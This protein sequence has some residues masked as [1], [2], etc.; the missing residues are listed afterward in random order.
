MNNAI[1]TGVIV[2]ILVL[3]ILP[4]YVWAQGI[5]FLLYED[6]EGRFTIE[7][8]SEWLVQPAQT[9]FGEI[10]VAFTSQP[11]D[12]QNLTSVD[13]RIQDDVGEGDPES[14]ANYLIDT[15]PSGVPDFNLEEGADCSKYTI[16]GERACSIIFSR[17]GQFLPSEYTVMQVVSLI[18]GNSYIITYA[19]F[20]RE[21]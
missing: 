11:S 9:R 20:L 5:E 8:P 21:F 12:Q 7:Y 3:N 15:Y 6:P 14:V 19:A 13:I 1:I 16:S 4:S 10:D 17:T 18:D 2:L